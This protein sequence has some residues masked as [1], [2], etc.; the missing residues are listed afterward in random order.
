MNKWRK[1]NMEKM[2]THF[3]CD[4]SFAALPYILNTVP[5]IL[6][7]VAVHEIPIL[8]TFCFVAMQKTRH[9]RLL[10]SKAFLAGVQ[11]ALVTQP[12]AIHLGRPLFWT[13]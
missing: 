5:R 8:D 10:T 4:L 9:H 11:V 1:K 2:H 3:L 13:A 7:H 6:L 12:F